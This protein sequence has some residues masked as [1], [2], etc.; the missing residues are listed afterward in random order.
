MSVKKGPKLLTCSGRPAVLKAIC[1]SCLKDLCRTSSKHT[2][3]QSDQLCYSWYCYILNDLGSNFGLKIACHFTSYM[4][5]TRQ[6]SYKV[7]LGHVRVTN[8]AVGRAIS[9]CV[10]C[11]SLNLNYPACKARSRYRLSGTLRSTIFVH[12][13]A[14]MVR[15]SETVI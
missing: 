9:V 14:Q 4:L 12:I 1:F 10:L 13:N 2:D 6:C 7:I 15:F 11:V 5:D 3:L 8:V